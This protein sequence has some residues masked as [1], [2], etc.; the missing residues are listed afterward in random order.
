MKEGQ[1]GANQKAGEEV[2]HFVAPPESG[3]IILF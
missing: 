2:R 1:E 3:F